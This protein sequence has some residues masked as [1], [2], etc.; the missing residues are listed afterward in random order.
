[1][2]PWNVAFLGISLAPSLPGEI[3]DAL[4]GSP[5]HG[6]GPDRLLVGTPTDGLHG[7]GTD[8]WSWFVVGK[9]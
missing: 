8:G 9:D 4:P 6:H 3:F 1:M 2:L 5:R 7:V